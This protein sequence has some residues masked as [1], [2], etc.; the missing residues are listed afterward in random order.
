LL[1]HVKFLQLASLSSLQSL[2]VLWCLPKI[3]SIVIKIFASF[4]ILPKLVKCLSL[5]VDSRQRISGIT[6][7]FGFP[8][9]KIGNDRFL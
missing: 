9:R 3:T 6:G 8:T 4:N 1:F 7:F 5:S 2:K